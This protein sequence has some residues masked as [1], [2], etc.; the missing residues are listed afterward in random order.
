MIFDEALCFEITVNGRNADVKKLVSVLRAGALDDFFE[1]D[2]EMFAFDDDYETSE[3]DAA[4]SMLFS[5]DEFGVEVDELDSD[6][7]LEVFC[8]AARTLHVNGTLYN[9]DDE[10][11]RFLSEAGDSYYVNA[12]NISV[13][14][15]ELDEERSREEREAGEDDE[16]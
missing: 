13:F 12:D 9:F 11:Y 5:S 7:F 15:D 2:D 14:N 4:T 1:I 8:K 10:E 6:E 16:D 3:P